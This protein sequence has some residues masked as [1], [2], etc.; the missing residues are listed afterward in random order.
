[1]LTGRIQAQTMCLGVCVNSW[2]QEK[3][4]N[5]W[6][7]A[8]MAHRS[9]LVT[10]AVIP[11]INHIGLVAM[12]AMTAII[13]TDQIN[14]PDLLIQCALLHDTI[15]D[16]DCTYQL[17]KDEFGAEVADGVLALT[18]NSDFSSKYEKMKDSLARIKQQPQ[19]V[20]MVK[21]C[22][23]ITNLQPPPKHWNK[24]KISN[25][26]DEAILILESLGDS[27]QYLADRLQ[28]KI[29]NYADHLGPFKVFVDDNWQFMD[30]SERY[31]LGEYKTYEEAVEAC[32]VFINESLEEALDDESKGNL[33]IYGRFCLAGDDPWIRPVPEGKKR[34]SGS[35]YVLQ[36]CKKNGVN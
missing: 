10:G 29:Y 27:N 6:N 28:N 15:E 11:Y 5:A 2:T 23:R 13:N 24:E 7:F 9:Q 34:F 35:E 20:W 16:T 14:D 12:E 26:R 25:Y 1:M 17:I 22:D 31:T 33:G 36:W 30:D 21:L 8:S 32:K 4:I 3:Y 19:E 18:K